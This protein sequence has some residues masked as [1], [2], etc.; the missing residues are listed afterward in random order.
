M[1]RIF[2]L[3]IIFLLTNLLNA[4]TIYDSV[5]TAI[6]NSHKL[7]VQDI[8]IKIK[9]E[10][11]KRAKA[12]NM[13]TVNLTA[14]HKVEKTEFEELDTRTANSTNYAITLK[15]NIYNG[16]Y[17]KN[18]IDIAKKDLEIEIIAF[19][20][21]K[22]EVIYRAILAHIELLTSKNIL[23]I[24]QNTTKKYKSL[25]HI[26]ESKSI[27][28]DKIDQLEVNLRIEETKMRELTLL[29]DYNLKVSNY[30]KV[31][32]VSPKN[33]NYNINFKENLVKK[34]SMLDFNKI[35]KDILKKVL[36]IE[37]SY[38]QI[39]QLNSKFLP[40][41]D[42]EVKAYK[43]EPLVQT[44]VTTENQ[45]SAQIVI[46]YNLYNG[47]RDN[48]DKEINKLKKLK[49]I[50][51]QYDLIDDISN[52]YSENYI[53]FKYSRKSKKTIE[54]YIKQNQKRYHT[55]KK[56]FKMSS[57]KGILDMITAISILAS[58]KETKFQ[59]LNN[60]IISYSNILLLQSKLST[61]I[62]R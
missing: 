12:N 17:D 3:F 10:Y 7:K 57:Q 28:G 1:P 24:T 29:Q 30:K 32:G 4:T 18:S 56:L 23:L 58:S 36:E 48:I 53:K 35:N 37:K 50:T 26:A 15:Q 51:E 14:Y 59:N 52:R 13:P 2:I 33:L 61:R 9:Q 42:L 20:K 62:L 43:A 5:I 45:Y 38:Y 55:Y 31:V 49:L 40:T 47:G 39:E 19:E 21:L 6:E 54:K 41:V 25:L 27:Y 46:N 8:E 34:V 11:I 60:I 44:E 22:Q 16:F